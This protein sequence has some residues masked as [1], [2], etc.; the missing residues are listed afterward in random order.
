MASTDKNKLDSTNIFTDALESEL[1]GLASGAQVNVGVEYTQS[2]KNKLSGVESG[3]DVNEVTQA[4]LDVSFNGAAINVGIIT[5]NR[6][7]GSSPITLTIPT[8]DVMADGVIDSATPDVP[9]Q[10]AILSTSLGA[11]VI[12]NFSTATV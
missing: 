10:R 9:N 1:N 3:A 11:Q 2:E 8:S 4:E 5:R 12:L 6:I 7:G